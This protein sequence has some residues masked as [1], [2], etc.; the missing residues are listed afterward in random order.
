[1]TIEGGYAIFGTGCAGGVLA[2]LLHWWNLRESPQLPAYSKSL[3]YWVVTVVMILAGG[4]VAWI[5]FGS[6][7]EAIIAVHVGLSAPLILQ[8]LVT[9]LPSTKGSKNIIATPAPTLRRFFTW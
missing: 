7:A 1:M 6:K 8:K 3:F 5:Y 2:E 9:S 4:F